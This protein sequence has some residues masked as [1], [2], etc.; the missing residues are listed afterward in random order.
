MVG[1]SISAELGVAEHS[2]RGP[3]V[4]P[5]I[6][7]GEDEGGAREGDELLVRLNLA[8]RTDKPEALGVPDVAV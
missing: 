5:G 1:E 8:D 4:S 3:L 7:A 6:A 2:S